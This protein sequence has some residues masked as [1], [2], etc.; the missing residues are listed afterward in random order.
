MKFAFL[1]FVLFGALLAA[2]A[3]PQHVRVPWLVLHPYIAEPGRWELINARTIARVYEQLDEKGVRQST[4]IVFSN[5]QK[6]AYQET[7][8][9]LV[10]QHPREEPD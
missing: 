9:E 2:M 7:L 1:A 5:G 3:P 10:K 6:V 4:V 8:D